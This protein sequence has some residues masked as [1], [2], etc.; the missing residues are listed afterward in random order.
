M[1]KIKKV[2]SSGSKKSIFQKIVISLLSK[3]SKG[4]LKLTLPN[5][6]V[7]NIGEGS[8]YDI[9]IQIN[10]ESFFKR[11]VFYGVIGFSESYMDGHWTTSDLTNVVRWIIDNIETSGV[12]SGSKAKTY[13][14]NFLEKFNRAKHIFNKNSKEGSKENISYHYDLSNDLYKLMLDETMSYSCG[15]FDAKD[16]TLFD[17]QINKLKHLCEDLDIQKDDH[18]LEIGCGWAGFASYAVKNYGCKVTGV[19]ISKEQFD[20]AIDLV[21]REGLEESINILFMDYRDIKGTFD[22]VVSIEMIEAVGDEFLPEYF[23]TIDKLLKPSG[24]ATI[25]AITAPDSR[26]DSFKDGV[27]FIQKHIFP[28]SL[29]PSTTAM[30]NACK[31]TELQIINFRDIGVHYAKTLRLWRERFFSNIDKVKELGFDDVFI[32]KWNYYLCYC[33]AA[34]IE[35]NISDIQVTFTKPNNTSYKKEVISRVSPL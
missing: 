1:E 28:G 22:K 3:F 10:D 34:F 5:G 35:R 15:I 4:T 25:Q 12:M 27:D 6:E 18:I 30:T 2:D 8:G 32:R 20:Y 23:Q 7:L 33:E 19:T 14:L 31:K 26:Y 13:G 29:L 17:A 9:D 21:K 11:T 16:S 24:V